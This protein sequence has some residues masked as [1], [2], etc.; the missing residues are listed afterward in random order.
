MKQLKLLR[1]ALITGS[2][3]ALSSDAR[4]ASVETFVLTVGGQ[5]IPGPGF[6]CTTFGPATPGLAFFPGVSASVPTDGLVP[7]GIAGLFRTTTAPTSGPISDSTSLSTTF[8]NGQNG[9]VG[10]AAARARSGSVSA[11]ANGTFAGPFNALIVEGATSY[12]RFTDT[13]TITSPNAANGSVGSIRL[14]FTVGGVVTVAG[15]PPFTSLSDVELNYSVNGSASTGLMRA[16]VSSATS[17]PSAFTGTGAPLAGFTLSP[18]SFSGSGIVD[19]AS[20]F[21]TWGTPFPFEFGLLASAIPGTGATANAQFDLGATLTGIELFA[22]GQ[23]VTTFAIVAESGTSYG[24]DG[25][26]EPSMSTLLGFGALALAL[27]SRRPPARQV[28]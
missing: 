11:R 21:F 17:L 25:V 5:S 4:A 18:G 8:N 1:F 14:R 7:C 24:A 2:M 20:L 16:Q 3:F 22:A 15:P 27:R 10:F 23:P 9:F 12:A 6:S 28:P 13:L 19:S 26:P